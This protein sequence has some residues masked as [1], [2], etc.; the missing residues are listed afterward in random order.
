[1]LTPSATARAYLTAEAPGDLRPYFASLRERP[2]VRELGDVLRTGEPAAWASAAAGE[3]WAGRL[4]DPAF[5]EEFTAAMDARGRVLAPA[6]AQVLADVPARRVLDIA[7]GSGA[8][9]YALLDARPELHVRVLERPPV[10][11]LARTLLRRRGYASVDVVAG[12]MFEGLPSGYDLHLFAHVFHDWDLPDVEALLGA[13]FDALPSGG[14]VVDYD[15]HLGVEPEPAVA[16]Y[17]A[18][19][20]HATK[21]RCYGIGEIS[22]LMRDVGF[23]DVEV[24]P[25]VGDRSA[26]CARR[27]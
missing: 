19:L 26:V 12:D 3:D 16:A 9:G 15:A 8:Y 20:M 27:P 14:R 5:A 17:S 11:A 25:T 18:L 13:S 23:V 4:G 7:G 24:R 6:L 22:E 10:D 2:A 1:M 21:G